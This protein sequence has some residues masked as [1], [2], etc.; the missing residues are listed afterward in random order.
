MFLFL[1]FTFSKLLV[2][3]SLS[4]VPFIQQIFT[5]HCLVLGTLLGVRAYDTEQKSLETRRAN[6]PV[7]S[8]SVDNVLVKV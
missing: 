1:F 6:I 5:K 8:K 3:L 7:E 4:M 2:F